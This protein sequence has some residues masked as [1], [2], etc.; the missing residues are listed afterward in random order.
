[1]LLP[2]FSVQA[3]VNRL[4]TQLLPYP[5]TWDVQES[6]VVC[7]A[8]LPAAVG[9]AGQLRG[10]VTSRRAAPPTLPLASVLLLLL[11]LLLPLLLSD[12]T[13]AA[14]V[15]ESADE[16]ELDSSA[17]RR[18]A[19]KQK[20]LTVSHSQSLSAMLAPAQESHVLKKPHGLLLHVTE[21]VEVTG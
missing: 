13:S 4:N 6:Q 8:Q 12:G 21:E 7:E 15:V 11:L 1:M 5:S 17:R 9:G 19:V 10:S 2:T 14:E 16:D 3:P 18:D 20:L